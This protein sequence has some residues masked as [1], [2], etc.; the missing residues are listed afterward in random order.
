MHARDA[1]HPPLFSMKILTASLLLAGTV[2]APAIT[3]VFNFTPNLAIPDNSAVGVAD[4]HPITS[5]IGFITSV[6][7]TL[8]ITGGFNGDY[9]VY[10][11]SE[12]GF[13]VLLNRAGLTTV[14]NLGYADSGLAVTFAQNAAN[15]DIHT[16][17]NVV[18]PGGGQLTGTWQ[19]DGRNVNPLIVTDASPRTALL[20][21]F[22]GT[23]ANETWTLFVADRSSGGT[24]TLTSWSMTIN[25]FAPE[26]G[27]AALLLTAAAAILRRHR[28]RRR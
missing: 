18:N 4:I 10:L 13:S 5:T 14:D 7:V 11:T 9:Y 20:D 2:S 15:G 1:N 16:Y 27:S 26:P 19:P 21:S 6:Q 8:N 17:Q 12:S 22:A 28:G 3:S 25:G 24:G 23:D